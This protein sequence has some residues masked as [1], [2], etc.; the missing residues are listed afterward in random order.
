M[1]KNW[2]YDAPNAY[3]ERPPR[4]P[5]PKRPAFRDTV[6]AFARCK[7]GEEAAVYDSDRLPA[8]CPN[9]HRWKRSIIE[10]SRALVPF[11]PGGA[12]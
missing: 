6:I 7:C 4:P 1:K 11:T 5:A 12:A 3:A 10:L 9:G 2:G 8:T